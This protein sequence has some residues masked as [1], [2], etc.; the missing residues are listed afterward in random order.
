MAWTYFKF[1]NI[2]GFF[3]HQWNVRLENLFRVGYVRTSLLHSLE[4]VVIGSL[5]CWYV[6]IPEC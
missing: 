6:R 5:M 3:V 2:C 4:T 1:L